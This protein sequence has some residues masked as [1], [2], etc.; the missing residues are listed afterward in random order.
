VTITKET[1]ICAKC[2][3]EHD[4]VPEER[5]DIWNGVEQ[6]GVWAGDFT[7]VRD[8]Y[9]GEYAILCRKH[10]RDSISK[11]SVKDLYNSGL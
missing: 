5:T 10:D 2:G 8:F 3:S 1:L 7:Y 11:T 6:R 9:K 4:S